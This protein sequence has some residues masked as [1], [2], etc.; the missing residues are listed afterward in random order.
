MT[1][2]YAFTSYKQNRELNRYLQFLIVSQNSQSSQAYNNKNTSTII[3]ALKVFLM[4]PNTFNN[5]HRAGVSITLCTS[6]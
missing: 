2:Y 3:K 4:S 5:N 1:V 6:A